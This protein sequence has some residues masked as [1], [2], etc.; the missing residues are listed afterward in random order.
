M[1]KRFLILV[2]LIMILSGI[3]SAE[4]QNFKLFVNADQIKFKEDLGYPFF[5]SGRTFVPIRFIADNLGFITSWDNNTKTATVKS[6]ENTI[7]LGLDKNEAIVNGETRRIDTSSDVKTVVKNERIYVP[8]RFII[9]NLGAKVNYNSED[10]IHN[11]R[12]ITED[13]IKK[14]EADREIIENK[15]EE[16]KEQKTDF[17]KHPVNPNIRPT[18]S[19]ETVNGIKANVARIK[20]QPGVKLR[21]VKGN[22]QLVG[23]EPFKNIINKYNP[24]LAVNG[25]YFDAYNTLEP[26]GSIIKDGKPIQLFGKAPHVLIYDDYK[27]KIGKHIIFYDAEFI[28]G[29]EV[30]DEIRICDLNYWGN[31]PYKGNTAIYTS[32]RNKPIVL[33]GGT[34]LE[35]VNNIVT[36]EYT[37]TGEIVIPQNGYVIHL[38]NG[39]GGKSYTNMAVNLNLKI[40]DHNAD[41]SFFDGKENINMKRAT[42]L[43]AAG[44]MLLKNGVNQASI[45]K[46]GYEAKIYNMK[47][48]RTAIGVTSDQ[49]LVIITA[50]AKIEELAEVMKSLGCV[51]AIN[52]DGGAS[53]ALYVNGTYMKN[54]GRPL[55]TVLI[56][57]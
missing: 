1:K 44:P 11:I 33:N 46:E 24:K 27:V 10:G 42:Q 50:V 45:D 21:V 16:S 41:G 19:V 9:E 25:N 51:D 37:P 55:N 6:N 39:T 13:E 49:T 29:G 57:E 20:L 28:Q 14:T 5:Q 18:A 30:V 38:V 3:V 35:V 2:S 47:A 4:N 12:I 26:I 53:S 36:R 23:S 8:L 43:I 22:D 40:D 7:I 34:I 54:A 52:L 17:V 15:I 32:Y 48:Q 31:D 56:M